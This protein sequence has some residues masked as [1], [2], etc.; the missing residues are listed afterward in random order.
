[1]ELDPS[2]CLNCGD[3]YQAR[4]LCR[5][6]QPAKDCTRPQLQP[7]VHVYCTKCLAEWFEEFVLCGDVG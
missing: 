4:A 2:R 3:R 7:H 1:M 5:P 6:D